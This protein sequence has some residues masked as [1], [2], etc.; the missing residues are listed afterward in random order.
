MKNSIGITACVPAEIPTENVSNTIPERY[1]YTTLLD[2]SIITN[3]STFS[4]FSYPCFLDN[5]LTDGG[6][7]CL[8]AGRALP[9]PPQKDFPVLISVRPHHG[10][11]AA[12]S[13]RSKSW[14]YRDSNSD[15]SVV[16]PVGSRD[17]ISPFLSFSNVMSHSYNKV[18]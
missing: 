4:I 12:G 17:I 13:I 6:E 7:V 18:L 8:R 9:P 1:R 14:L 2:H 3:L 16:Q 5:R 15:S 10:H 11:N